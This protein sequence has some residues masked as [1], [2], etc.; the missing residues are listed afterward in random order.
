MVKMRPPK[1]TRVWRK[2]AGPRDDSLTA[3]IKKASNGK[4]NIRSI[5]PST[6]SNNC[7]ALKYRPR[8]T[9]TEQQGMSHFESSDKPS[10]KGA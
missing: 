9:G 7:F 3:S 6:R 5:A 2:I 8:A 1:P 10:H 4:D